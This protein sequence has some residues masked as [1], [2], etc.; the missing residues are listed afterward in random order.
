MKMGDNE[1][2]RNECQSRRRW[3]IN[4]F[5]LGMCWN[6][7]GERNVIGKI[8]E[9][10]KK[11]FKENE[12]K[13][14]RFRKRFRKKINERKR[15]NEKMRR[16]QWDLAAECNLRWRDVRK[17]AEFFHR[18]IHQWQ[19]MDNLTERN[20]GRWGKRDSNEPIYI[21]AYTGNGDSPIGEPYLFLR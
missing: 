10:V 8:N 16:N 2:I 18:I 13:S 14:M 3:A 1:I 12:K 20:G 4:P 7:G 15:E 11:R 5:R 19:R 9:R 6:N 17:F 21:C